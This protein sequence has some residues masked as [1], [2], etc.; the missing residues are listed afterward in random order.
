MSK[1]RHLYRQETSAARLAS[2]QGLY[3]LEITEA[4]FDT[5]FFEFLERRWHEYIIEHDE[6][7]QVPRIVEADKDKF[8]QII[9]DVQ[10]N[11]NHID[12]ILLVSLEKDRD[13]KQLDILLKVILRAAV[14]ELFFLTSV[15]ARVVINE[16]VELAH[17]FY[18]G[19]EPYLVN[20]V[21]DKLGKSI[22]KEEFN[23]S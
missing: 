1:S 18:S 21:L 20:G 4:D 10:E 16:Y 8:S 15:P 3:E 22:R 7:K 13:F 17:A 6:E 12:G 14:F 19:N 5:V 23:E 11:I 2:V 9:R